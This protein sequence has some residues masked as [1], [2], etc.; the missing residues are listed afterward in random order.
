MVTTRVI[1]KR[2]FIVHM[3]TNTGSILD[4]AHAFL[5]VR[6]FIAIAR[7]GFDSL[8]PYIRSTDSDAH[9]PRLVRLLFLTAYSCGF[10]IS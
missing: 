10:Y 8:W 7:F 9:S 4:L 3:A 6:G 2:R 1:A 5:L